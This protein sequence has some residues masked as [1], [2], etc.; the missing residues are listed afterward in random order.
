VQPESTDRSLAIGFF[1]YSAFCGVNDTILER[2]LHDY[3]SMWNLLATLA[4][5]AS[6]FLWSWS[7]RHARTMTA[8]EQSLISV[9]VY[10]SFTPQIN[11]RLRNLN[12]QLSKIWKTEVTRH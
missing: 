11:L 8:M 2:Y 3:A 9:E 12:E 4:F 7:L 6:L 1:L 10:Q 5:L